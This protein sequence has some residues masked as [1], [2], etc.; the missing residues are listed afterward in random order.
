MKT[1]G[2]KIRYMRNLRGWSQEEIADRLDISLSAYS[3]I[4]KNITDL[5]FSRLTQ[6]AKVFG[7]SVLE[8]FS[9]SSKPVE[10]TNPQKI[11]AEKEKEINRLQKKIIEL[12]E[13]KK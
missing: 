4:E 8:L 7:M 2:Q 9:V 6:I 3:K 11:L 12:M 10:Q 1:L 13:K 5:N